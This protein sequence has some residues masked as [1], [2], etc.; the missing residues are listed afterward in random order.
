MTKKPEN[1]TN[2]QWDALQRRY[3]RDNDIYPSFETFEALFAALARDPMRLLR[4]IE[5][6]RRML[7]T[8][9]PKAYSRDMGRRI[10]FEYAVKRLD[11]L[12]KGGTLEE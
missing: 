1:Y 5:T 2:E 11:D 7:L 8:Q 4:L 9:E 3:E 10:E 6:S 12:L